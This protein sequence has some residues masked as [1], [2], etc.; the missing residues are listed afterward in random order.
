MK[1]T[2]CIDMIENQQSIKIVLQYGIINQMFLIIRFY[3]G[4][5]LHGCWVSFEKF[6]TRIVTS[7]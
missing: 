2:A 1:T 4:Q 7:H 5:K 3:V 6:Q